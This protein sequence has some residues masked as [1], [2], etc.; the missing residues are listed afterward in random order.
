MIEVDVDRQACAPDS[1]ATPTTAASVTSVLEAGNVYSVKSI[2]CDAAAT[3]I[4]RRRHE[5]GGDGELELCGAPG[6]DRW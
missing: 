3:V 1:P 4:A 6:G 2:L 5:H